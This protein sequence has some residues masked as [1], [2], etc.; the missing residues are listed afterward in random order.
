MPFRRRARQPV[1]SPVETWGAA[2]VF[3]N[4]LR[5]LYSRQA[6]GRPTIWARHNSARSTKHCAK[7]SHGSTKEWIFQPPEVGIPSQENSGAS[8]HA[9]QSMIRVLRMPRSPTSLSQITS[10]PCAHEL[11]DD[12]SK[13]LRGTRT[14]AEV[15]QTS[16]ARG[17]RASH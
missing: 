9:L 6:C 1:R 14:A 12:L 16:A 8:E 3:S 10:T 13:I 15:S 11:K 5:M 2:D 4:E 7:M 17:R